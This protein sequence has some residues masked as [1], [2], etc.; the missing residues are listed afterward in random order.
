MTDARQQSL[1][2]AGSAAA[3][4]PPREET[5]KYESSELFRGGRVVIIRTPAKPI[6]CC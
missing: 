6:G 4:D 1:D 3:E 2:K 5:P